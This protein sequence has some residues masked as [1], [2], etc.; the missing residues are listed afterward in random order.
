MSESNQEPS[1]NDD[2]GAGGSTEARR[3]A[4]RGDSDEAFGARQAGGLGLSG[5]YIETDDGRFAPALEHLTDRRA[6]EEDAK[7]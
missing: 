2:A 1:A 5:F 6:A 3:A 7:E 4:M